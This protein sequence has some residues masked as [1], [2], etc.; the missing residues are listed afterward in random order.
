[1]YTTAVSTDYCSFNC[2]AYMLRSLMQ[3]W[4]VPYN[5]KINANP[6]NYTNTPN[7]LNVMHLCNLMHILNSWRFHILKS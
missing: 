1:M 7:I 6:D 3:I 2:S 5:P 4:S